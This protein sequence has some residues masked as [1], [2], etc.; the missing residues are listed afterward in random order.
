MYKIYILLPLS[1]HEFALLTQSPIA[2]EIITGS[3]LKWI[4]AFI[5]DKMTPSFLTKE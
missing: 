1:A 5:N 2:S 4:K 3:I